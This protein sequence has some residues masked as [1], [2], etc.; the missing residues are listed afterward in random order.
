[1][2]TYTPTTAGGQLFLHIYSAIAK[3]PCWQRVQVVLRSTGDGGKYLSYI[4]QH[5]ALYLCCK[6]V[7]AAKELVPSGRIENPGAIKQLIQSGPWRTLNDGGCLLRFLVRATENS[8]T[9]ISRQTSRALMLFAQKSHSWCY[10]C[11]AP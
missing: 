9:H 6:L 11:G 4:L 10:I 8:D 2:D 5:V 1:M 3:D 7:S